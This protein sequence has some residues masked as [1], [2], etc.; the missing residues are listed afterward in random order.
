IEI[1]CEPL[2]VRRH[3]GVRRNELLM[4]IDGLTI[5]LKG[6]IA[7]FD[8]TFVVR[9]NMVGIGQDIHR[10]RIDWIFVEY[11]FQDLQ[12][13]IDALPSLFRITDFKIAPAKVTERRSELTHLISIFRIGINQFT[14]N[15]RAALKIANNLPGTTLMVF[16]AISQIRVSESKV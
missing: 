8:F 1:S 14:N 10:S 4:K 3:T 5:R 7:I 9:E 6:G 13:A 11:R 2:L 12:G 15:C 16:E